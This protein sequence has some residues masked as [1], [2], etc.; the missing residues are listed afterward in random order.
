MTDVTENDEFSMLADNAADVGLAWS[1]PPAVERREVALD[2]GRVVSSILWGTD[3][4]LVFLHGGGQNA[5]TWDTVVL[6]MGLDALAV[7]LPGHG[8]SPRDPESVAAIYDPVELAADVSVAIRALAPNARLLTGMSLGGLTSIVLASRQADLVERIAVVDV[9]PGVSMAKAATMSPAAG[10]APESWATLE[11][12]I[13][14]TVGADP[15]RIP[16]SLRRGVIHNTRQLPN[17]RWVWRH[18]RHARDDEGY[19]LAPDGTRVEPGS[20]LE[21]PG[22]AGRDPDAY[23]Y[24]ELWED[25]SAID[26]PLLLVV[27]SRSRVVDAADVEEL[28]RRRPATPVVT[29]DDAGHR[30]Q[31][32]KPVELAATLTAFLAS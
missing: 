28:L 19:A 13:E 4:E 21:L 2:G 23:L 3:P 9:T 31:G 8:H 30:V 1:G 5:H 26:Q 27:G 29:I 14:R 32:D 12:I 18:D 10:A 22:T 20:P 6:A 7:D 16:S 24:P 15:S 25:V 11:E 17:G